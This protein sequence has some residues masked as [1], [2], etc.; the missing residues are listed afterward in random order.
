MSNLAS[1]KS[2]KLL[3]FDCYGT[4]IDW[5]T[6]FYN[7]L[8]SLLPRSPRSKSWTRKEALEAFGSV[9]LQLQ[10]K[11]PTMLYSEILELG[12]KELAGR[13]EISYE[14]LEEDAKK[15]G[16]SVPAW[17]AFPDSISALQRLQKHYKMVILSN[18]DLHSFNGTLTS[19]LAPFVPDLVLTAQEIGSYKPS[20]RNFVHMLDAVEKKFGVKPEEVLVTAQSLLHDHQPGHALGLKGAWINREGGVMGVGDEARSTVGYEFVFATLGEMAG[21]VEAA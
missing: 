1:L 3:C 20:E 5:E 21:A 16:A 8:F 19:Q 18:V 17:T 9:E 14:G 2:F 10:F 11:H 6:G 7:A 13:L 4:I 15:F 12:F